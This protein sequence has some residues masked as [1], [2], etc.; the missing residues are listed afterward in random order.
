[1]KKLLR[2]LMGAIATGAVLGAL[3]EAGAETCSLELKRLEPLKGA[4]A[5]SG[6]SSDSLYRTTYPQFFFMQI[7]GQGDALAT[8]QTTPE[9][10]TKIVKKEPAYESE[11]PFRGAAKLGTQQ[12]AF[13]LDAKPPESESKP[14]ETDSKA[15]KPEPE[16]ANPEEEKESEKEKPKL[17][18]YNRLYFDLNHN[19]DLTDDEVIEAEQIPAVRSSEDF[20]QT[21][22]PQVEVTIDVD[23]TKVDYAFLLTLYS[24]R[25]RDYAYVQVSLNAAAYREGKITLDGKPRHIVVLDFNSNGRFDD[26]LTVR[27]SRDGRVFSDHG[28]QLLVDP[29][30]GED[31]GRAYDVTTSDVRHPISKIVNID[32]RF[33]DVEIPPAGDKLT[34]TP[35]SA[36]VGFVTNP[37]EGL[38]GLVYGDQGV[39]KISAEEASKPIPLPE[40]EWRLLSYTLDRT[41]YEQEKKEGDEGASLL[42]ALSDALIGSRPTAALTRISA[43]GTSDCEAVEVRRGQTIALPF[44]PP[45]KPVV[46]VAYGAGREVVQLEML[47]V[48]SG[49]ETCSDLLVDGRQPNE[50]PFTISTPDGDEVVQDKFRFG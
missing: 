29:E 14:S 32:G 40:G 46:K 38:R 22:F 10:S 15:P 37:H 26:A 30:N 28:D 48:G 44:G 47:L 19:G 23:G 36:P 33:Y 13:A 35:S 6:R 18:R 8:T 39:L 3:A 12:Y 7:G 20:A 50:A 21:T 49:G 5:V 34:L 9:F 4:Q 1:M 27:E 42:G 41:G 43:Q 17:V 16:A 11:H 24:H 25:F 2:G 31:P 45:Y